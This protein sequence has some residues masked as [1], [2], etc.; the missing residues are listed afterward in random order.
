M[1]ARFFRI[2]MV[3]TRMSHRPDVKTYELYNAYIN[4]ELSLNE[5]A[6]QYG[7][8]ATS[9]RKRFIKDG[10]KLRSRV[11]TRKIKLDQAILYD[12]YISKQLT[13]RE[14][15]NYF[16][17][18]PTIV[19][20]HLKNMGIIRTSA[21]SKSINNP[22]YSTWSDSLV[23]KA[24][25]LL[26]QTRSVKD[27]AEILGVKRK[28]LEAYNQNIFHIEVKLWTDDEQ[29]LAKQTL[30]ETLSYE[31]TAQ[32]LNST[33]SAIQ[34]MNLR[35]W[36]IQIPYST[37]TFGTPAQDNNGNWYR[38]KFEAKIAN[39]FISH[40]IEFENEVKI[41]DIYK[42]RVDFKVA[43]IFIEAD[44][45]GNNRP[46]CYNYEESDK[47]RFMHENNIKLIILTPETWESLLEAN[48][49]M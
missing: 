46:N 35:H 42:W 16:N 15:A 2:K 34:S 33:Y 11:D 21:E 39:W 23:E 38:S 43:D 1:Q 26:I 25:S 20:V 29:K 12:L 44:G 14:I 24:R 17:C 28:T 30:K 18:S 9:V 6:R 37:N 41:S 3:F 8:T 40:N 4:S 27:V 31:E 45:L 5:I 49:H 7:M 22:D 36:H 48:L 47:I 19:C 32:K 10:L 13:T